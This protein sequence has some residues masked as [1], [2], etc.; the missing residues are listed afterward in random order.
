MKFCEICQS[1]MVKS[2]ATGRILFI[3]RCGNPP[4]EGTADDSLMHEV[5]LTVS[6]SNLKHEVFIEN[7]PYDNAA[8][9]IESPCLQCPLPYLISIRVGTQEQ[10]LYVCSCGFKAT[11]QEY[12]KRSESVD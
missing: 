9:I 3:C 10:V 11:Y 4:I 5:H 2:T 6:H 8:Y 1:R 7:A 12:M